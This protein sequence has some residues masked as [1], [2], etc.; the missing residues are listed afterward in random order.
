MSWRLEPP[1]PL[2]ARC[3]TTTGKSE[4]IFSDGAECVVLSTH[5]ATAARCV[6]VRSAAMMPAD[7]TQ[8]NR[9][10]SEGAQLELGPR[11]P[12]DQVLLEDDAQLSLRLETVASLLPAPVPQRILRKAVQAV[13]SYP[14]N[15][16]HTQLTRK[17]FNVLVEVTQE[18]FRKTSQ[19]D[20][21]LIK[22]ARGTPK[23]S[24]PTHRLMDMMDMGKGGHHDRVYSAMETLFSWEVRWNLMGDDNGAQAVFEAVTSRIISQ[25]GKGEGPRSGILTFEFPHDVLMMVLEPRPYAQLDLRVINELSSASA[26]GLY[27][28]CAR[29]LGTAHKV[30]ATLPV[31]EWIS[32]IAAPGRYKGAYFDFS[33]YCL[34]PAIA[35]LAAAS[36]CP[37]TVEVKT[38]FGARRKVTGLQF[39]MH[40]KQQR[41]LQMD[42]PMTWDAKTIETLMRVYG[43]DK[44]EIVTLSRTS[45]EAE[46]L[47]AVSRDNVMV[48]KKRSQGE[49]IHN[50]ANY[51][52][53]ILRN[54]QAGKSRDAEPEEEAVEVSPAASPQ[55]LALK[56]QRLREEFEKHRLD[57]LKDELALLPASEIGPLQLEFESTLAGN[58]TLRGFLDKKGWNPPHPAVAATFVRWVH[59]KKEGIAQRMLNRPQDQDFPT[60][61]LVSGQG[62]QGNP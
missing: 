45:S 4:S 20:R 2:E 29:Y 54:V 13:H 10:S 14:T 12:S 53:G 33:R 31:E 30:T 3:R 56:V 27:E 25:W 28:C 7:E 51:L 6:D 47:E 52:K 60:W 23:F 21:D 24:V 35:Q 16:E 44:N 26:I 38:V 39:K 46:I 58:A 59:D 36:S 8:S 17:L 15:G 22:A 32:L 9:S 48:A 50:R 55:G 42:M 40:M 1:E 61:M 5:G 43:M 34:K 41:P 62:S 49:A 37:F 18:V 11:E 57:R 19:R